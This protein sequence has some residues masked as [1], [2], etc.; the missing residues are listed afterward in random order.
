[1][2]Q[3]VNLESRHKF[4]AMIAKIASYAPYMET[5]N[6]MINGAPGKKSAQYMKLHGYKR[7]A[8][9]GLAYD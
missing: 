2:N 3:I 4:I 9:A 8:A 5:G 1:M 6:I 7:F